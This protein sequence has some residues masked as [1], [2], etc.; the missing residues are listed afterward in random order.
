M[1]DTYSRPF[2]SSV[3]FVAAV[4]VTGAGYTTWYIVPYFIL[5]TGIGILEGTRKHKN[6]RRFFRFEPQAGGLT[7]TKLK[8]VCFFF[9]FLAKFPTPSWF[10]VPTWWLVAPFSLFFVY[11]WHTTGFCF[12]AV[13]SRVFPQVI[14]V[15]L[16]FSFSCF[17]FSYHSGMIGACLVTMDCV[18]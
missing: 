4:S 14:L 16:A 7:K 17:A 12:F 8:N 6:R 11:P 9:F 15:A 3:Y 2:H 5:N 13:N 10:L 1:F 18:P